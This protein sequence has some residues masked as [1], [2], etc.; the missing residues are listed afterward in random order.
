MTVKAMPPTRTHSSGAR[1]RP[2]RRRRLHLGLSA[3]ITRAATPGTIATNASKLQ[4]RQQ[5][6]CPGFL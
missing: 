5:C 2:T 4:Q 6:S 3:A 1:A